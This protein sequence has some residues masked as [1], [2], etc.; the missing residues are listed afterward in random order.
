MMFD[1]CEPGHCLSPNVH[2]F[3]DEGVNVFIAID[4]DP[5]WRGKPR[6]VG[7][8]TSTVWIPA[9]FLAEG[10]LTVR[11]AITTLATMN[12]RVDVLDAV[13]FQMIDSN[14]G[15]SARGDYMG[16][17]PGVVR[18]LLEWRTTYEPRPK[19]GE[20]LGTLSIGTANP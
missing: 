5:T 20:L 7:R 1:V 2:L 12:V 3:N 15:D 17:L 11:A 6:P 19:D 10:H 8:Y 13:A 9:N 4:Q 16:P 14:D 18:P